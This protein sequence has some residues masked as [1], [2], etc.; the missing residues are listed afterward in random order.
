[1]MAHPGVT[2]A[3][4]LASGTATGILLQKAGVPDKLALLAGT[5]FDV[6]SAKTQNGLSGL[7]T[8]IK[9]NP[10]ITAVVVSALAAGAGYLAHEYLS[11]K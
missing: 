1:M 5:A 8:T 6:A 11:K 4:I 9:E 2:A 3:V 10:V 7:V